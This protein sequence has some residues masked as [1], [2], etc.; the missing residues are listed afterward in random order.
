M[1][2]MWKMRELVDKATNV[3]MNYSE[4]E[5]KVREATNDDPW[6]PSGQLMAEIAKSTFMYEQFP[7]IMNMLWTRTLKD[8]KKNWRRVYKSLLLLAYLIRNGSERV[9]TS[10]REHI[11]DL[12]SMENYHF[13]DEN[14]KDQG[15]NVR[16]KVKEM[17][18]F[19]Q[20]DDR[21]REERK[22][23]KKNKDK[24]I[25]V[26]SDSMGGFRYSD[27]YDSEP[28]SKWDD[29]WDKGNK[30]AFP[31]SEKLGEIS[32]KIGSTIDDTINKFRKKDK[33][34]SPESDSEEDRRSRNHGKVGK[35]EY[36]D[37][38]ET[39]T[40]K[41]IHITQ[42]TETTTT[43]HKRSGVP[44]KTVDLGAAAHYTGDSPSSELSSAAKSTAKTSAPS[45]AN[46]KSQN[47][48]V[49]L[50]FDTGFG[51]SQTPSTGEVPEQF[52]GF[53][54]FASTGTT[55]SGFPLT[56]GAPTSGNA[57]FGEWST[58]NQVQSNQAGM[59]SGDVYSNMHHAPVQL[60]AAATELFDLTAGSQS[61]MTSSQSMNFAMSATNTVA[62]TGTSMSVSRS[63]NMQESQKAV[64]PFLP[65]TWSDP[66]VNIS[67]DFL[68]PG[69]QPPKPQ[70]PS[71][72]T[73]MQ[74][75][76]G[77]QQPMNIVAQNFSTIS[78]N[79]PTNVIPPRPPGA[80]PLMAGNVPAGMGL[81][82]M[83][84]TGAIGMNPMGMPQSSVMNQGMM[85]MSMGM[86]PA[87][88]AMTGS[89]GMGVP[90]VGLNA[91]MMPG[92][93]QSKQ[94]AFANFANFSK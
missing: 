72:N 45:T 2:N 51:P 46:S 49:D 74:Q 73:M 44:S 70:Q 30:G 63:Q 9:V 13:V 8:N 6:G 81:Q 68:T 75:Q 80:S 38:E 59:L 40:T 42:A 48:L 10:A 64:K 57:D 27:R 66:S 36:K 21:L 14:G 24:Y 91:S 67:L 23:A 20:D 71:L 25:G 56:P 78:I 33:D 28:K 79:S 93:V 92:M 41:S 43:R 60:P 16:Q 88:M 29:D 54:D 69:M 3:V 84:G 37:E 32:D 26:S 15:I 90:A 39:V 83:M 47:D 58:F 86:A 31:F 17:V 65:S 89:M 19:V 22:K 53:A 4:I 50:L 7:E 34:D 62:V 11:Y 82:N 12:R 55:Q 18:E 85:G 1:L 77:T 61:T 94:D 87:G 52:G 35:S 5:S 76:Q